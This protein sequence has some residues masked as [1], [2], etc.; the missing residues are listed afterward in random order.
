[1]KKITVFVMVAVLVVVGLSCRSG[2]ME[3]K[4][5]DY[6]KV[7]FESGSNYS[8]GWSDVEFPVLM[9]VIPDKDTAIS[10]AQLV[11]DLMQKNEKFPDYVPQKVFYAEKDEVWIVSFWPSIEGYTGADCNIAIQKKDGRVLQIW[12]GE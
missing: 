7:K 10:F 2:T 8:E 6:S 1:M 5:I 4:Q 9:D 12:V 11:M 3:K